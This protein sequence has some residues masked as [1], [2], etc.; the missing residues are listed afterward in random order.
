MEPTLAKDLK[1]F[2]GNRKVGYVFLSKKTKTKF[3]KCNVIAF[4]NKYAKKSP[5]IARNIGSHALR[6][7]YASFMINNGVTIGDLSQLLGHS[8]IRTTMIYLRT[9]SCIDTKSVD[10]ALKNLIPKIDVKIS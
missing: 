8:S 5:S 10:K 9:I 2:I 1:L 3:H 7:T 4:I 6:R